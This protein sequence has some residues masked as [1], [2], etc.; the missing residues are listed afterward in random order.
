MARVYADLGDE[1][2]P[3]AQSS[4]QTWL[5]DNPQEKF[6]KHEYKLAQFGLTVEGVRG[7][8]ERYLSEYDVEAE[9]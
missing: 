2:T 1:F 7:K 4:M 9:G 5:D 3:A 8:F 6:G